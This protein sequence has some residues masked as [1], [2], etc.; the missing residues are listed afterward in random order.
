MVVVVDAVAVAVRVWV[1]V[2]E[3]FDRTV[4]GAALETDCGFELCALTSTI[5]TT[6]ATTAAAARNASPSD[7]RR[8][9]RGR[10]GLL[11]PPERRAAARR[12]G[13][14][15]AGGR[16]FSVNSVSCAS[17]LIQIVVHVDPVSF[18]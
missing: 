7:S 18:N 9:P 15:G 12:A 3:V 11:G 2:V 17:T 16:R 5:P 1:A 4:V 6:A 10:R 14:G 13:R 8:E